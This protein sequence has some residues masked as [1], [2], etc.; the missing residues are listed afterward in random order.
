[1]A[2]IQAV[3]GLEV[4]IFT[5]GRTARE[6]DDPSETD[7]IHQR[8]RTVTE[9]IECKDDKPFKI[10]VKATYQYSWGFKDHVLVFAA[11][12]DGIWAKGEICREKDTDEEDWERD[13]SY[14]VVESPDDPARYV[15]QEFAFSKIIKVGNATDEQYASDVKRMERLGTIEVK[16]YRATTKEHRPIFVPVGEHPECFAVSYEATREKSQSHGIS[17]IRTQPA[18]KPNYIS[19][20]KLKYDIGPIAIFRFKYRARDAL[21]QEGI[22]PDPKGH[23]D[24]LVEIPD[25]EVKHNRQDEPE[26]NSPSNGKH[27]ETGVG[28]ER[29]HEAEDTGLRVLAVNAQENSDDTP[30][31][32]IGASHHG[33][34]GNR[35]KPE[36]SHSTC[37]TSP[38]AKRAFVKTDSRNKYGKHLHRIDYDGD[39]DGIPLARGAY[40][41][42]GT[43]PPSIEQDVYDAEVETDSETDTKCKRNQTATQNKGGI[44]ILENEKK[45]IT[46]G[47]ATQISLGQLG[48]SS[49]NPQVQSTNFSTSPR[50]PQDVTKH[51]RPL[52]I[53][54]EYH[55]RGLQRIR[56]IQEEF[57]R[58]SENIFKAF[59]SSGLPESPP[60]TDTDVNT[61][62]N[63]RS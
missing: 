40:T 1:M 29:G 18:V 33:G 43:I 7:E 24:W 62:L 44:M 57:N 48:A 25:V 5:N 6:Y 17:F 16:V 14:R 3:P 56:E 15:L 31:P 22:I 52:F 36:S 19:C 39:D 59:D 45:H 46:R 54:I 42:R 38:A 41:S 37:D 28:S 55:H 30:A 58:I 13:I 49:S 23:L 11:V 53:D 21:K 27:A 63:M 4:T 12:T 20:S 34:H 60:D 35:A 32:F 61:R 50:R 26:S 10:H 2:I 9:Y 47:I 8:P 51:K